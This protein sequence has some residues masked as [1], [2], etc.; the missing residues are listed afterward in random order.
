M[1]ESTGAPWANMAMILSGPMMRE[2]IPNIA[3]RITPI[4]PLTMYVVEPMKRLYFLKAMATTG[5]LC[6]WILIR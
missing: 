5:L 4:P 2:S 3:A 6:L 1:A